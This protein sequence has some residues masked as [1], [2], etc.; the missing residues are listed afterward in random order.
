M[1]TSLVSTCRAGILVLAVS[2]AGFVAGCTTVNLTRTPDETNAPAPGFETVSVGSE[3]DF[4][5]NVGRRTYFAKGSATLDATAMRTLD[6]QAAWLSGNRRWLVKLQGH[7]D[8]PG[9]VEADRLLSQRRAEAVMAYLVT[10]GVAPSR[11][12]AKGYAR[13]RLV[14]DCPDIECKAQ[15]RRVV[16]N[17]RTEKDDAAP[18]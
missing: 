15:N 2:L 3:E 11:L 4:I 17:L 14:R 16:S 10:R 6:A 5:I 13:D 12:W 9:S 7:A 1:S 8:D 18:N